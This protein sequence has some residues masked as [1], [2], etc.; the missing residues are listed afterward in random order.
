[1]NYIQNKQQIEIQTSELI[2]SIKEQM[3]GLKE[4]RNEHCCFV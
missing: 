1:M 2:N 3:H 4:A